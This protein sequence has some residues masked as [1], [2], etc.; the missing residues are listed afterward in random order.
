MLWGFAT[1]VV[2]RLG[3]AQKQMYHRLLH[4][5]QRCDSDYENE[6]LGGSRT[7]PGPI[8]ALQTSRVPPNR[9]R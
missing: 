3:A 5:C 4:E 1:A 8:S 9:R 7:S 2:S 6:T